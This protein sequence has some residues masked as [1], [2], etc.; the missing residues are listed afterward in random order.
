MC[1]KGL[2]L[3]KERFAPSLAPRRWP[4]RPWTVFPDK[5]VFIYLG[6]LGHSRSSMLTIWFMVRALG[7]V[8]SAWPLEKVETKDSH[9]GSHHSYR[10]CPQQNPWTW[11]LGWASL[12]GDNPCIS[13]TSSWGEVL[14]VTGKGWKL[15]PGSP[16]ALPYEPFSTANFRLHSGTVINHDRV[17]LTPFFPSST[18]PSWGWSWVPPK[19]HSNVHRSI[20]HNRLKTGNNSNDHKE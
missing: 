12:V 8:A 20:F 11:R 13:P 18:T 6:A 15:A 1:N 7:H 5:S 2:T 19:G 17:L 4:L 16:R 14:S 10:V 3:P 9:M